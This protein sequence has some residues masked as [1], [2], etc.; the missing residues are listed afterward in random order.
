MWWYRELSDH[1]MTEYEEVLMGLPLQIGGTPVV[2][3]RRPVERQTLSS[4]GLAHLILLMHALICHPV[5]SCHD[6]VVHGD[7]S[8]AV[9]RAHHS[10]QTA[11]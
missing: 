10:R 1:R 11:H 7:S 9:L 6:R 3:A 4:F 8:A 2:V 5:H